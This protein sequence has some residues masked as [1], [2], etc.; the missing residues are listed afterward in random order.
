MSIIDVRP[1][2]LDL[3]RTMA[4]EFCTG[5]CETRA[6]EVKVVLTFIPEVKMAEVS[7]IAEVGAAKV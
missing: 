5:Q 1:G 2:A 4:L 7:A 6:S 3:T